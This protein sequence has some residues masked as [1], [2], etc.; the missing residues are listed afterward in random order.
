MDRQK[1]NNYALSSYSCVRGVRNW[2]MFFSARVWLIPIVKEHP[3]FMRGL[4]TTRVRNAN[5]VSE[6]NLWFA[7]LRGEK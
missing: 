2:S 5:S 7:A 4:Q 6:R 3:R 1:R